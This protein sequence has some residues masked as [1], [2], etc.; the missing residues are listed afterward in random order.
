MRSWWPLQAG[1]SCYNPQLSCDRPSPEDDPRMNEWHRH[2]LALSHPFSLCVQEWRNPLHTAPPATD[3][4]PVMCHAW[5]APSCPPPPH[6]C[7]M[8]DHP[9]P[10]GHLWCPEAAPGHLVTT[11]VTARRHPAA[12]LVQTHRQFGV[13]VGA[14]VHAAAPAPG[15][16][17][18]CPGGGDGAGGESWALEVEGN[19]RWCCSGCW[20]CCCWWCH[21]RW[22][23]RWG[24]QHGY[25]HHPWQQQQQQR[26]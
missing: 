22:C 10:A 24:R 26:Q 13:P 6:C 19:C 8:Q 5:T 7:P 12:A 16:L 18:G 9:C 4:P 17:G 1:S 15:C 3:T 14:P 11:G 21:C 2:V 25:H 23:C 20:W